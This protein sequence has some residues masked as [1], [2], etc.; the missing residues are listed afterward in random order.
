MTQGMVSLYHLLSTFEYKLFHLKG[1]VFESYLLPIY[2]F[3]CRCGFIVVVV[4]ISMYIL[5]FLI[6]LVICVITDLGESQSAPH[7]SGA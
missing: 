6:I 4:T 1:K 5:D 7:T 3:S 2:T